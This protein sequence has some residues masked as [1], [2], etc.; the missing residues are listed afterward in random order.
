MSDITDDCTMM[1]VLLPVLHFVCL[2][3][4]TV[5]SVAVP[6]KQEQEVSDL[7]KYISRQ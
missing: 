7:D 6:D 5:Y 1:S 2:H 3:I 4:I